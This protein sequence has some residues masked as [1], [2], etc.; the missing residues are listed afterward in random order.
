MKVS[1]QCVDS[2]AVKPNIF[3]QIMSTIGLQFFFEMYSRCE[4]SFKCLSCD[5]IYVSRTHFIAIG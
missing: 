1:H 2:N 4:N 3:I 5:Y